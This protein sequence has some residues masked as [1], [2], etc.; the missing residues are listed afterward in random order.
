MKGARTFGEHPAL[1]A[2]LCW[3]LLQV[4]WA[5]VVV[6]LTDPPHDV[7]AVQ[8]ALNAALFLGPPI[9]ATV[10]LTQSR[11]RHMR[12]ARELA[13]QAVETSSGFRFVRKDGRGPASAIICLEP[14]D[15]FTLA[16]LPRAELEFVEQYLGGR[17]RL[18]GQSLRVEHGRRFDVLEFA[19]PDRPEVWFDISR[20]AV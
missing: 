8:G 18:L 17:S 7:G 16:D 19:D 15:T 11:K 12:E 2:A 3:F 5:V 9:I 6:I 10:F 13:L 14:E 4:L 1:F 20:V